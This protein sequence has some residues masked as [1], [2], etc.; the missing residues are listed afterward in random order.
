MQ[1]DIGVSNCMGNESNPF[2]DGK[3]KTFFYI[4]NITKL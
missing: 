2:G 4:K 1:S 3:M